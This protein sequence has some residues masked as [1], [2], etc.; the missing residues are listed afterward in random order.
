L[1]KIGFLNRTSAGRKD[2]ERAY[3]HLGIETALFEKKLF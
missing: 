2:T 1:L 3:Q